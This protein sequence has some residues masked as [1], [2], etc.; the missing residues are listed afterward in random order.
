[1]KTL[2]IEARSDI[3]IRLSEKDLAKLP[4]ELALF[5]T[6]QFIDNI[7]ALKSQLEKHNI[8]VKLFK[9]K[10]CKYYGQLLGCSIDKF[11]TDAFLYIGD[12]R[13]HP[14]ALAL[15]NNKPV[16]T[17]NPFTKK[18]E[19][20]DDIDI[21]KIQGKQKGALLKFHTSKEIGVLISLKPGQFLLKEALKLQK[22]YKEKNFYLLL[23]ETLDFS[24]L[25][26]FPFIECY[27]NTA[28]PRL[29]DDYDKF[30]KPLI[31]IDDL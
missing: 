29:M 23:F 22:K 14:I 16:F 7:P 27:V 21:K 4:K 8:K 26:N 15:K 2:F 28:C 31:N 24:Q 6:V 20:L 1:M 18:L 12:G 25:E 30:T 10:H 17:Y 9:S 3:E 11:P 19:K 5:T 13:F